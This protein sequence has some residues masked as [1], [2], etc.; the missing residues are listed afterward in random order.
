MRSQLPALVQ[1]LRFA[2]RNLLRSPGFTI[3]AIA[4]LAVGIAVN[5]AVFTVANA[6]L[7]KGFRL[8]DHNDRILYIDTR[9]QG[10]GCCVS[11]PDF[12]DWRAQATSFEGMGAVA[13]L[14]ITLSDDGAFPETYTATQITAG[15][16]KIL[17]LK[18][19]LGRDFE[20]SDE[21]PGGA[22]V[23]IL[24]HSFWER[25][26][27]KDPAIVGRSVRINGAPTT[28]IGVMPK[29]FSFPQKQDLWLPLVPSPDLL[30]RETRSLWFAFGRLTDDADT[31]AARAEM[32]TIGRRLATAHPRANQ[33]LPPALHSFHEFFIGPNAATMYGAMLGAVV[34]VLLIACANLANL[35]LARA[36]DR[37]REVCLR[38][39]LGAGRWRLVRQLLMESL[40]LSAAGGV[41]GWW[42]AK[43]GVRVYQS[44]ASPPSWFDQILDY[45]MDWAVVVYLVAIS[46][47]T[48]LL[49]GLAPALRLSTLDIN[50]QLKEGGRG[51]VGGG[52]GK[53]LSALLVGGEMA[54]AM[55]LLA[56]AGVMMRSFLNIY[57]ASLGVKTD[58]VITAFLK[59]PEALYP[60]A[61]ARISFFDRL[62]TSLEAS[63]GLEAIAMADSLPAW[64]ARAVPYE[65]AGSAPVDEHRRPKLSVLAITP[66]YFQTL[67]APLRSGREFTAADGASGVPAAI[68][69]QQ[70]A[71]LHWPGED[72]VGKRLRLFDR[73]A[74]DSWLTVVGV[75]PN[76]VQNDATRQTF[77]PLIYLPYRQAPVD[78]MW[79]LARGRTPD[80]GLGAELR[81]QVQA[82]DSGLPIW[83]GP[84]PLTERLA[85]N[86]RSQG[87][88]GSLFLIFAVVA[89]LL[90][91]VGLYAVIA[92]S[93]SRQTQ[94]MG[95]R[96]AI[97][98]DSR[99]ILKLV[100]A[101][102][103]RPLAIGLTI[104]LIGS[105]VLNRILISELVGVSPSDA[106]TLLATS[107]ALTLAA[108]LGCWIPARRAA[109]V[110]PIIALRHE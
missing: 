61:G 95:V 90:A 68:V 73:D 102:G 27:G 109:R 24:N 107:V 48:G 40:L 83:L 110:D 8:V 28:V 88:S 17:G 106:V 1:D 55:V 47:G 74:A 67:G 42:L 89:L 70:F 60:T 85:G 29:G 39:A 105:L 59:L 103:M 16:F 6:V 62:Q 14:R 76:I 104:G 20:A 22:P 11:Y 50:A 57:T 9:D 12:Q 108:A 13:D 96:M 69:N 64:G 32:E 72:A 66:N 44:T 43:F 25:R 58:N 30:Q 75:A 23:A 38:L 4:T 19:I 45:N 15:A 71:S 79:V 78:A 94:E 18:P 98:A 36:I 34:F 101:Q 26:Y 46:I 41:I 49:F 5:V 92:R 91:S 77:D 100:F 33:N 65:I 86:Y 84:F 3:T 81:R 10:R 87:A 7:F 2:S 35:L 54:L 97:G 80:G 63:P 53:R 21:S 93:V 51:A 82:L 52:R 37:S 56:G 99:E 31:A